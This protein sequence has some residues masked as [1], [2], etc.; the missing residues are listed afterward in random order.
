MLM[1]KSKYI[2]LDFE[3]DPDFEVVKGHVSEQE[4]RQIIREE[5]SD[6]V[7]PENWKTWQCYGRLMPDRTG[8]FDLIL[9]FENESKRG[10]W[11][12][13]IGEK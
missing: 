12:V 2:E 1:E 8:N 5:R 9:Y 3:G 10:N 4:F 13:T 7:I 6:I 11:P